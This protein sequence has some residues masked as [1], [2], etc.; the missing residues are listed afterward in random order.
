MP[1]CFVT[2]CNN[3][4]GRTRGN[5][6]IKYH[7]LPNT[8]ITE[9]WIELCGYDKG[10]K[11]P[12]FA[13][14]CSIHFSPDCYQRDLEHELLGLPLRK[15]LRKD[16][17]P[18]LHLPKGTRPFIKQQFESPEILKDSKKNNQSSNTSRVN[19]TNIQCKKECID[20]NIQTK[21]SFKDENK[22]NNSKSSNDENQVE[23]SPHNVISNNLDEAFKQFQVFLESETPKKPSVQAA[24]PVIFGMKT[25]TPQIKNKKPEIF[26]NKIVQ[27]SNQHKHGNNVKSNSKTSIMNRSNKPQVKIKLKPVQTK[28]KVKR[29]SGKPTAKNK[30][31]RV[32]LDENLFKKILD[33]AKIRKNDSTNRKERRKTSD[34]V[35]KSHVK[36]NSNKITKNCISKTIKKE[37]SEAQ[38]IE[39]KPN[40]TTN[41][42]SDESTE[43]K[44]Q[45][46]DSFRNCRLNK[47]PMRSSFRIAKKK[48][49]ECLSD[50]FT[51]KINY[52]SDS[53]D[54][55]VNF[56]DKL[57]FMAKLQLKFGKSEEERAA[58]GQLAMSYNSKFCLGKAGNSRYVLSVNCKWI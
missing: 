9:K 13:R 16:A 2:S 45:T 30:N 54:K 28:K 6:K 58:R 32:S 49:I 21:T 48:S 15:K 56:A 55:K 40:I 12:S 25:S 29:D 33:A 57:K 37:S 1:H 35:T 50:S 38:K 42:N 53:T 19:Q 23:L 18:D 52:N 7:M 11:A 14:V 41:C 4:Y 31:G 24:H 43:N 22:A 5:A 46:S 34:G 3:Y 39:I 47:L 44:A 36:N 51:Y 17:L 26:T 27:K 10:T 8:G 20:C